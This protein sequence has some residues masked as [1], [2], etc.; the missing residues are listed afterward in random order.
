LDAGADPAVVGGWINQATAAKAHAEAE[1][2]RLRATTPTPLG[3]DDLHR[4]ITETGDLVRVLDHA[5]STL[6]AQLYTRLGIEGLYQPSQ[7]LVVITAELVCQRL[8]SE[9]HIQP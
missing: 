8:V 7:R 1:R 9:D 4:M 2:A 6:R 3:R 5:D